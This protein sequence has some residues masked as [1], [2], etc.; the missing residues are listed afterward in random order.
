MNRLYLFDL[1]KM[2]AYLEQNFRSPVNVEDVA[3]SAGYSPWHCRRI[4]RLYTGESLS[5]R[6]LR[7]RLE[8][9]KKELR[10][11]F[12]VGQVALS[13]GFSSR[14]GFTK[15]F[16]AAYGISPG[17]YARGEE[18]KERYREVY[19]YRM[20]SSQWLLGRNPTADGLWEFSYFDPLTNT[21]RRMNW[22]GEYFEAPF[23]RA[24][25]EDPAWYCRN[26]NDGYGLHP[27][28]GYHA[29]KSFICPKSG[30]LEYFISL[31][32]LS[33]LHDG[34]NPCALRVF[35]GNEPIF[36]V[37]GPLVLSDRQPIRIQGIR[38]V[39]RGDRIRISVDSMGHIGRDGV[40]LY[41]QQM[42]YLEITEETV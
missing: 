42:G 11:G 16:S 24:D 33:D 4:F 15:A 38:R 39:S 34:S 36:P 3:R 40:M 8:A 23:R 19:E 12:P 17:R 30:L 22:N 25:T 31:G 32:R 21:N 41:R 1:L 13:V 37:E 2:I 26:R 9:G 5:H 20:T 10:E 6:L 18:T 7:F 29:V 27:G 28:K 14:E 35:H